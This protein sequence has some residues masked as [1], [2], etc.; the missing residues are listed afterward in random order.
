MLKKYWLHVM[1]VGALPVGCGGKI[2]CRC[3]SGNVDVIINEREIS[4]IGR[5]C[6]ASQ[7][8]KKEYTEDEQIFVSIL[9]W[10]ILCFLTVGTERETDSTHSGPM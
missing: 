5:D 3:P 10:I 1:I 4:E 9:L 6:R 2:C 8:G 7:R